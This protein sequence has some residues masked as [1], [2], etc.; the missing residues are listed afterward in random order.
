MGLDRIYKIT[1]AETK[2]RLSR[3]EI[4]K[5]CPN[6]KNGDEFLNVVNSKKGTRTYWYIRRFSFDGSMYWDIFGVNGVVVC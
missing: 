2:R 1:K 4:D 6:S 3:K 5:L